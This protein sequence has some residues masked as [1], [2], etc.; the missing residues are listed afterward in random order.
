MKARI[1]VDQGTI[2]SNAATGACE[3][4]ILVQPVPGDTPL[5]TNHVAIC[6]RVCDKVVAEVLYRQDQKVAGA[7]VW[8]DVELEALT[9]KDAGKS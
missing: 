5:R 2:G 6:C 1:I 4:V 9:I 7:R 8:I 3:P